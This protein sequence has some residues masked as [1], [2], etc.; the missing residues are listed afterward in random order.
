MLA[1]FVGAAAA[2]AAGLH[3]LLATSWLDVL[4]PVLT[5][6]G[7]HRSALR[8]VCR[9]VVSQGLVLP[10]ASMVVR[11]SALVVALVVVVWLV[12]V[13]VGHVLKHLRL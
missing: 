6:S 3:T 1:C 7:P 2:L 10:V 5:N 11:I 8:R 4:G 9:V 12:V 13:V